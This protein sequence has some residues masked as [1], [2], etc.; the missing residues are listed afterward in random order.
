MPF[1]MKKEGFLAFPDSWDSCQEPAGSYLQLSKACRGTECNIAVLT[2]PCGLSAGPASHYPQQPLRSEQA[3][4]R[5]QGLDNGGFDE[6]PLGSPPLR[7]PQADSNGGP[8]QL[9]K[10]A[11]SL[12]AFSKG[13][14]GAAQDAAAKEASQLHAENA[15]LKQRLAAVESVSLSPA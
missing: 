11:H 8:P 1:F 9:E 6:V 3:D 15:T 13:D 7:A 10:V 2:R 12:R 14:G 4:A 5:W